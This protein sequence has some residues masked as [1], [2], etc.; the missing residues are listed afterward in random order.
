MNAKCR[1][2]FRSLLVAIS[3]VPMLMLLPGTARLAPSDPTGAWTTARLSEPRTDLAAVAVGN[4]GLFA[5]GRTTPMAGPSEHVSPPAYSSAV[6]VYD[7]AT[8]RWT[9]ASL[10]VARDG[11]AAASVGT[12]ALF[13]GGHVGQFAAAGSVVDSVDLYDSAADRWTTARLSESRSRPAAATVGTR[14]IFAGGG[15][16]GHPSDVVDIYDSATDRWSTARLSEPRTAV[17]AVTVGS[18]ALFAGGLRRANP[19][20]DDAASDVIDIYDDRTGQWSTAKLSAGR[21][22][23][24]ALAV[25]T[26]ALFIGLGFPTDEFLADLVDIY[27]SSADGW[28]TERLVERRLILRAVAVGTRAL[29]AG[30]RQAQEPMFV[31]DLFD[32]ATSHWVAT[33]IAGRLNDGQ[34]G[35]VGNCALFPAWSSSSPANAIVNINHGAAG[36]WTSAVLSQSRSRMATLTVGSRVLLAGGEFGDIRGP[37]SISDIVDVYDSTRDQTRC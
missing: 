7:G 2:V 35:V 34:P 20:A 3:L 11:L 5:A 37:R 19:F 15:A 16:G 36:G 17:T 4:K 10:S 31:V 28:S 9:T 22:V 8:D 23:G 30:T 25:G 29:I 13:A 12:K 21:V 14:A 18:K 24:A 27:D 32:G 33:E 26:K 1:H 6:D